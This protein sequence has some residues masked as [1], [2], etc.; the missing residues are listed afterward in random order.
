MRMREN[1][2][3]RIESVAN[4]TRRNRRVKGTENG[5]GQITDEQSGRTENEDGQM[6]DGTRRRRIK[7]GVM[8]E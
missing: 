2:R 7:N 1:L 8:E 4:G 5:D 6:A 3:E